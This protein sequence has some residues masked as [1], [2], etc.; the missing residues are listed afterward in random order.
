MIDLKT[1]ERNAEQAVHRGLDSA[2][3]AAHR[4]LNSADQAV[5]SASRSI[6]N[7]LDS[8]APALH[9]TAERITDIAQQGVDAMRNGSGELSE[10]AR[11]A[12]Y[13]TATYIRHDPIKSVLIA[14]AVGAGA[15]ALYGL[16]RQGHDAEKR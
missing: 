3:Q 13:K 14:A 9:H 5:N 7:A 12:S 16:L 11:R 2:E 6:G 8:V 4:G 10:Q 15:M 1:T